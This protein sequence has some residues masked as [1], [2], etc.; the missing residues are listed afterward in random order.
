[1]DG[2]D[3][4]NYVRTRH[5]DLIGDFGRS[6]RQQ[7]V[8]SALKMKLATPDTISQTPQLLKDL[9]GY[10]LTDMQ[11]DDLALLG[12]L[13][14]NVDL[15][16]VQHVTLSPPYS[17]PSA[18]NTNYLPIC[19]QITPVISQMFSIQA[20]CIPQSSGSAGLASII[21]PVSYSNSGITSQGA[22]ENSQQSVSQPRG[23]NLSSMDITGGTHTLL[24]IMLMTVFESFN[25]VQV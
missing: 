7:Q 12:T 8:L 13:A 3:A 18:T 14:R 2:P 16:S 4:L 22:T 1:L 5:S 6:A 23:P 10:L 20:S 17:T 24:D 9:N 21:Q 15:N 25:A 11:L 19:S